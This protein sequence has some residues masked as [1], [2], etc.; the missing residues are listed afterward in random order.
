[1]PGDFAF[2][3]KVSK[4]VVQGIGDFQPEKARQFLRGRCAI[5]RGHDFDNRCFQRAEARKADFPEKPKASAVEIGN[6]AQRV[7]FSR[8]RETRQ[9]AHAFEPAENA[10]PRTGFE[11]GKQVVK[12]NDALT[13]E[14][15]QKSFFRF[16]HCQHMTP[17]TVMRL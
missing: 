8:I 9:I 13:S 7:V 11:N 3:D 4:S 16:F 15:F 12:S 10:H 17:D 1:M 2:S 5:G 14:H 6:V